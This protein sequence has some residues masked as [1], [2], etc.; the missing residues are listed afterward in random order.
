MKLNKLCAG[1]LSGVIAAASLTA[2]ASAYVTVPASPASL[3][4]TN[5]QSWSKMISSAYDIDYSQ[6]RQIQAVIT[7]TDPAAYE[8]EK[9]SGFYA[10]GVTAFVEFSGNIAF[11]STSEWLAYGFDSLTD[12]TGDSD[13]AT[14]TGLGNGSY[15]LTADIPSA[16]ASAISGRCSVT[17]AEWGNT[18]SA[19]ELT[20]NSFSLIAADGS[21]MLTYDGSGNATVEPA[22]AETT[23]ATEAPVETTTTTEATTVATTTTTTTTTTEATTTTTE[24]VTEETTTV[25]EETAEETT[26][27]TTTTTEAV[28]TTTTTEAETTAAE[29]TAAETTTAAPA[30]T[31]AVEQAVA[32]SS[33]NFASR[34]SQLMIFAIVAIAVIVVVII[35]FVII[36][37]KKKK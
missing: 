10:D 27:E 28:T 33:D 22:I 30:T 8:A 4:T 3:L 17:F 21:T 13:T 11:G 15:V 23:T 19:Y 20:L 34:N 36:A 18:S 9:A 1:I 12:V 24:A 35:G 7:L 32:S 29:T 5:S 2:P 25:P 6:L 31:K 16:S 14:L 26:E 37:I